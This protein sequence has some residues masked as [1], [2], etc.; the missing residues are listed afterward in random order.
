M[1]RCDFWAWQLV[2]LWQYLL[3][4]CPKV[5]LRNKELFCDWNYSY[6]AKDNFL[7]GTKILPVTKR[8]FVAGWRVT[9]QK[10]KIHG[11][12]H[13]SIFI[14]STFVAIYIFQYLSS[15]RA[16]FTTIYIFQYLSSQDEMT[17]ER[18]E[19]GVMD[20]KMSFR[21]FFFPKREKRRKSA[22]PMMIM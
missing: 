15:Q 10:G 3:F 11:H 13:L 16:K 19:R 17:S 22:L 18:W 20:E 5:F 2:F 1:W 8:F 12:L 14:F 9:K 4:V 7:I 21:R 6:E